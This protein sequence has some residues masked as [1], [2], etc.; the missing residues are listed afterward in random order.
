ML[1][2][3]SIIFALFSALSCR[4][5]S[6]RCVSSTLSVCCKRASRTDNFNRLLAFSASTISSGRTDATDWRVPVVFLNIS[7]SC[8]FISLVSILQCSKTS[9]TALSFKRSRAKRRCSGYTIP[10][11]NLMASSLLKTSNCDM[12]GEK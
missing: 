1:C 2:C 10:Q 5:A 6:I 7:S 4:I 12:L 3:S 9:I 11:S 8:A